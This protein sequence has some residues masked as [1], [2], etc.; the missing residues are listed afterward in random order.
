[1]DEN[2][3]LER[4]AKPKVAA[5]AKMAVEMTQKLRATVAMAWVPIP[6][7][8]AERKAARSAIAKKTFTGTSYIMRAGAQRLN[9]NDAPKVYSYVSYTYGIPVLW[10]IGIL[11]GKK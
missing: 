10:G 11:G 5:Q 8:T 2:Q 7:R 3:I 4:V 9:A 6:R 1:M